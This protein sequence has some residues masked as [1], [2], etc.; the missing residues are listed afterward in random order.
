MSVSRREFVVRSGITATALGLAGAAAARP[1]DAASPAPASAA[2]APA[3]PALAPQPG[4]APAFRPDD[5]ASV[6]A[7]FRL[8]PEYA[9]LSQFFIVSHPAPV[10]EAIER[11]RAALDANPYLYLDNHMFMKPE[12]RLWSR[13]CAAAA[14]YIG[15]KPEEVALTSSTTMGLALVYNG[16][17]IR[18][19]QEILTTTHDH[20]VHHESIRFAAERAGATVR[21][22]PLYDRASAATADDMTARLKAAIGPKTRVVG[23]TWAH[24]S[25]GVVTPI[26]RFAEVVRDANRGRGADD[27]AFLVVDGAHGFGAVD[28]SVATLGCDFLSAGTH[29][30]I[31]APRGT[32]MVWAPAANWALLRP[33]V[34]SFMS[35]DGYT[36]WMNATPRSSPI[37]AADISPGG[38]FAY[39]HQWA[40][41]EAFQFH[42]AIGRARVAGRIR[43]LNSRIK[44]G[45]AKMPHVTLHTPIDPA[46]SAGVNCFE[47]KGLAAEEVVVRLLDKRIVASASP[48]KVTYPRL[49]AGIMNSEAEIDRALAAV[50]ALRA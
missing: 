50:D 26:R 42:K 7:Q 44:A 20:F 46:L 12:D 23:V 30:W 10:R 48:Y 11:Y 18:S 1:A 8:D 14:E 31:M 2:P 19:G 34:P 40:T 25:T 22:S 5:W 21:R 24:S 27:R 49:S 41:V 6:R 47:V 37:A 17:P 39:E 32:G 38:F 28:E 35:D 45:L 13:V 4:P 16:L 3:R 36:S 15:G 43:E 9:H 33:T 29:K